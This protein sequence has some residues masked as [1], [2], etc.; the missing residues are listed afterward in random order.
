LRCCA[1][2]VVVGALRSILGSFSRGRCKYIHVSSRAASMRRDAPEKAAEDRAQRASL[3]LAHRCS[4]NP[5]TRNR[6]RSDFV[7]TISVVPLRS[8]FTCPL[9]APAFD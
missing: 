7:G 3:P 4:A 9:Y 8:R 1:D 2:A 5:L 6:L